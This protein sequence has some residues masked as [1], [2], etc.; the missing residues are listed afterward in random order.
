MTSCLVQSIS[1][2]FRKLYQE[3]SQGLLYSWASILRG[4]GVAIHM[5]CGGVVGVVGVVGYP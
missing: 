1:T 4:L 5:C 2:R 3:A